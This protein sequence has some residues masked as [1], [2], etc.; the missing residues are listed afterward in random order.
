MQKRSFKFYFFFLILVSLGYFYYKNSSIENS[1]VMRILTAHLKTIRFSECNISYTKKIFPESILIVGHAYGSS[2]INSDNF[3]SKKLE[4]ILDENKKNISILF[5][6]GDV[7]EKA[8]KNKWARLFN[9][10]KD[11]F[12]IHIAPGNHDNFLNDILF[13]FNDQFNKPRIS[14]YPYL[15]KTKNYNFIIEDSFSKGWQ[16]DKKVLALLAKLDNSKQIFILRHNI[17]N[18]EF[19]NLANSKEGLISDLPSLQN[20]TKKIQKKVTIISGDTGASKD[21]PSYFCKKNRNITVLV[22]GIGNLKK[23]NI[24]ILKKENIYRYEI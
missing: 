19:L 20:L 9:K 17:A 8:N 11:H 4:K 15:I 18:A 1:Y 13:S 6:T 21:L 3:I 10:Y 14:K 12:E 2:S 24:L 22:N 5:L 16:I 23:D 7:F